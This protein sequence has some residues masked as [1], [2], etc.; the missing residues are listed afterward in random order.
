MYNQEISYEVLTLKPVGLIYW[1]GAGIICLLFIWII[2]IK[3]S[4]N[5]ENRIKLNIY[6]HVQF[7]IVSGKFIVGHYLHE[8]YEN[9]LDIW[10]LDQIVK[11]DGPIETNGSSFLLESFELND[12]KLQNCEKIIGDELSLLLV[13]TRND[14][15]VVY[16][17][18]TDLLCYLLLTL[19]PMHYIFLHFSGTRRR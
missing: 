1:I 19:F 18:L 12:L 16:L 9:C 11:S 3:N 7:S 5:I 8:D 4:I 13:G 2:N 10:D 6:N 17:L 15:D 14:K